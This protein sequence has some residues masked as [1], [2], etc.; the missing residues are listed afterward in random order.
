MAAGGYAWWYLDALSPPDAQGQRQGLALIAFVGSVFSPY[1]AAQ[2]RRR[3][4][5]Q[6]PAEAHCAVNVALYTVR[7]GE[8]QAARHWCMTERGAS[9]LQRSADSLQIGP[10]ALQWTAHGLVIELDE[11]CVPWPRALRG[12][13]TVALAGAPGLAF[14]LDGEGRHQWQPLAP[15]A[16]VAVQLPWLG[17]VWQGEAY[18]DHN[19]GSRPLARD[20]AHWQWQRGPT[21]GHEGVA[22]DYVAQPRQGAL[23][24][25]HLLAQGQRLEPREAPS[26]WA[27]PTSSWGLPRDGWGRRPQQLGA[28]LETGPFYARSLLLDAEGRASVHESLSLDRFDQRWVQTLLPFRMPRRA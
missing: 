18:L 1:Y 21:A 10:S 27:L 22:I 3:G 23:R 26:R 24:A 15:Q 11:R 9:R 17:H 28:T 2:R 6:A 14:D 4:D 16:R 8:P 12:H 5:D 25:L 13:I 19:R 20:F 7:P